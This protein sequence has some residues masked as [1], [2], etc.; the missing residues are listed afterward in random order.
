MPSLQCPAMIVTFG[1]EL[2]ALIDRS[3]N[4]RRAGMSKLETRRWQVLSRRCSSLKGCCHS[5]RHFQNAPYT[6]TSFA[7][8][9]RSN[10][11]DHGGRSGAGS[12]LGVVCS[13][14][15]H[16]RCICFPTVFFL[17]APAERSHVGL[18]APSLPF[19]LRTVNTLKLK[20]F[21]T[22]YNL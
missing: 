1:R 7:W 12:S 4:L 21:F 15:G 8:I 17:V 11:A 9:V 18:L 5:F 3:E 10:N 6:G 14:I 22:V 19:L 16:Q 20:R 13:G 2:C